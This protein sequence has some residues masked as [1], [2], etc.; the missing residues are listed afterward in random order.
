MTGQILHGCYRVTD[1]LP[2]GGF[3]Q[4]YIANNIVLPGNPVC[5]VKQ[6]KPKVVNSSYY[7]IALGKFYEEAKHLARLGEYPQIPRLLDYFQED[8][9]FYLVQEYNCWSYS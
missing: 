8:G 1:I 3:G 2:P 5:V 9:Q 7:E 4:T 6:L